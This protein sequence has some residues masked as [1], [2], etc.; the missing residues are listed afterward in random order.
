MLSKILKS[1]KLKLI[2]PII[3]GHVDI[4]GKQYSTIGF[5]LSQILKA[6]VVRKSY[7]VELDHTFQCAFALKKGAL[8]DVGANIGQSPQMIKVLLTLNLSRFPKH[9]PYSPKQEN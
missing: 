9:F 7:E 1:F 6:I 3:R 2:V 8:L 4:A 5:H